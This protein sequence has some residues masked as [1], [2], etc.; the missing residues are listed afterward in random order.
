MII[1]SDEWAAMLPIRS[2]SIREADYFGLLEDPR[3][4][5]EYSTRPITL[6]H[7]FQ[8]RRRHYVDDA[9]RLYSEWHDT[10]VFHRMNR[11]AR[12]MQFMD[13]KEELFTSLDI[14]T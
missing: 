11:W 4:Y 1:V 14:V 13:E 12:M 5:E 7:I 9:L 6:Q 3:E 2:C 8:V 10:H